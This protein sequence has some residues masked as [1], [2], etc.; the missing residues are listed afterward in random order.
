MFEN[1]V[2]ESRR[3]AELEKWRSIYANGEDI[4]R[5][6]YSLSKAK[7][8]TILFSASIAAFPQKLEYKTKGSDDIRFRL[9]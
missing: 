7:F 3:E 6:S 5:S 1:K 8:W 9:N 4:G 2:E